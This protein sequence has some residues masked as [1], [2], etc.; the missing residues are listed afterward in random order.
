MP[1]AASRNDL[2]HLIDTLPVSVYR[3]ASDFTIEFANVCAAQSMKCVPADIIGRNVADLGMDPEL[4]KSWKTELSL[5]FTTGQPSSFE[6]FCAFDPNKLFE[7]RLVPIL[8]D[9]G[10][11]TSVIVA[12][13]AIEELHRLRRTLQAQ[14]ELFRSFMD[15]SPVFAW[16]RDTDSRY[17]FMNRTYLDHFGIKAEDRLGKRPSD[18][19]PPEVATQFESNDRAVLTAGKPLSIIEQAPDVDGTEHYWLNVKFPFVNGDNQRYIGGVGIDITAEK[20]AEENRRK[21][22]T[23]LLQAQKLESLGLL[24]A[25]AAHDFN[26]MLT[27][28]IGHA[29]MARRTIDETS[30][31]AESLRAIEQ[32][33]QQMSELCQQMLAFAGRGRRELRPVNLNHLAQD[34]ARLMRG[35]FSIHMAVHFD[36]AVD[37]PSVTGDESQLRQVLLNL[38][39]NAA[40]ALGDRAGTVEVHTGIEIPSIAKLEEAGC[41]PEPKPYALLQVSDDGPGMSAEVRSKIFE[42]FFTTKALGRGLGL[43]AVQGIVRAHHGL[44]EVESTPGKGTTFRVLLPIAK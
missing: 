15:H 44:I 43:A 34:T 31:A 23:R 26:N 7:Y 21:Q 16:L 12:G 20:L 13:L 2:A 25:G 30:A 11:V 18:F 40:D 29:N 1:D 9:G 33:G 37:L 22:E 10:N 28:V 8:D 19:Y 32:A 6:V 24:A 4:W 39:T 35:L 5:A 41:D 36:L 42:P 17:V 27:L 3:V 38:F 14:E